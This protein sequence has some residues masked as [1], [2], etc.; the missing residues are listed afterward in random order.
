MRLASACLD[1][2]KAH[3]IGYGSFFSVTN[4]AAD[5]LAIARRLDGSRDHAIIYKI[6]VDFGHP[7]D[8]GP[9]RYLLIR[10]CKNCTSIR[11]S[12]DI[13]IFKNQVLNGSA[14]KRTDKAKVLCTGGALTSI[15]KLP[16]GC[17]VMLSRLLRACTLTFILM[18]RAG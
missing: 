11:C 15:L 1:F 5:T 13:H 4:N 12:L 2:D 3:A 8:K 6:V 18:R 10:I 16:S 14:T 7:T 9:D 17:G